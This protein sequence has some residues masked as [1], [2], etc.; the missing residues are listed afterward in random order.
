MAIYVDKTV[1][2]GRPENKREANEMRCYDVLDGLGIEYLRADH[3]CAETIEACAA[4]E[5]VLGHPICKNLFLTNR[6][7]TEFY[8]L[9]MA[10]DKPFKT[11]HL[12]KQ[13]GTAR[14]SFADAEAMNEHLDIQP[15]S[16]SVLGILNDKENRVRLIFDRDIYEDEY[17]CCHPCRNTSTLKIR[18]DDIVNKLIP[19]SRHELTVVELPWETEE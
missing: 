16:V 6:Q 18:K 9:L 13:L 15:G 14:L 17:I 19:Y 4:V 8:L 11:K 3:D 10:G 7:K 12:S 1:Y 5:E 2:G